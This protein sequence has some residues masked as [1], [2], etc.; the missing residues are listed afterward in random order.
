MTEPL[1]ERD[2]QKM[3]KNKKDA[4]P[5]QKHGKY[6]RKKKSTVRRLPVEVAL[7]LP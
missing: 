5:G 7:F 2:V 6:E 1:S 4:E 3:K